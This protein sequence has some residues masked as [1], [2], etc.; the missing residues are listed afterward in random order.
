MSLGNSV[1]GLGHVNVNLYIML[2]RHLGRHLKGKREEYSANM[3]KKVC[4]E[5]VGC[6]GHFGSMTT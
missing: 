4:K 5:V 6:R 2:K 3:G 1:K